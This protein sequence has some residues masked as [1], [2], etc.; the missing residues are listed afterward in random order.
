MASGIW[1]RALWLAPL[2]VAPAGHRITIEAGSSFRKLTQQL[3]QEGL[4][5]HPALFNALAR[6][7]G[8]DA[9][10]RSGEYLL[11][12]GSTAGDLLALIQSGDTVRY[13]V[14]LPEGVRLA[15][16]IAIIQSAEGINATLDGRDDARLREAFPDAPFLEGLFLA[17]TY[18][19]ERGASDLSI[20]QQA[21]ELAIS[22]VQEGWETRDPGLPYARPDEVLIMA[23]IIEKETAVPEERPLIAGVFTRRL[24]QGMRLQTDPTVIYG[25]G[26]DFNGNLT[27]AHLSDA[28]NRFNTYRHG[29]LPPTPIALPGRASIDAA[30]NPAPGDALY[31]VAKGDGSHAFNARLEDHE[32]DVRRYQLQRRADYRSTPRGAP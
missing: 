17:E 7:S 10:I 20:L 25:L 2:D 26:G 8:A 3:H 27:R 16:A 13:L 15:E 1:L 23:S 14:T 28:A 18:Q 21:Y 29:G 5:S 11:P 32:A 19:Y 6:M 12:Q 30:L 24:Q 31:F 22:A 4:I 9:R